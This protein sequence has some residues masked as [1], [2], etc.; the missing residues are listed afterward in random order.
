MMASRLYRRERVIPPLTDHSE[1]NGGV[2][3]PLK[4]PFH[5]WQPSIY[6]VTFQW[7]FDHQYL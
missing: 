7:G 2:D 1:H 3:R 5:L 4:Y 6:Y